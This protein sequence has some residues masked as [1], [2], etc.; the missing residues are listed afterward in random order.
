MRFLKMNGLG[1]DFVVLDARDEKISLNPELVSRIGHRHMG[2][3][4]DQ[5]VVIDH[6]KDADF[7]LTFWNSDGSMAGA[8]GNATRCCAHLLMNELDVETITLKTERGILNAEKR[9]GDLIAVN[10]GHAQLEWD[11]IP[12]ARDVDIDALPIDGAPMAVGMGNP[13]CVFFVYDAE[14]VDVAGMGVVIE[15]HE[16]Y[17]QRTNVEFVSK[18]GKDHLRMRVWERGGMITMACGSG[19]CASVVAANRKGL[20]GESVRVTLDGGDL[21]IDLKEDGVWMTGPVSYVFEATFDPRFLA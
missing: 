10:M 6:S 15:H 13:H 9:A 20:V 21:Q 14:N 1:N 8:C 18:L 4:F 7:A 2:V 16:L 5:L 17:P 3:G 12:L 11:Q 19:T